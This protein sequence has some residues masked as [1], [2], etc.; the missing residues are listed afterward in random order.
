MPECNHYW[1]SQKELEAL[2]LP[3][4]HGEEGPIDVMAKMPLGIDPQNEQA[5]CLLCYQIDGQ[6]EGTKHPDLVKLE[7]ILATYSY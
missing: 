4:C 5:V 1:V 6:P 2:N 7:K 3:N